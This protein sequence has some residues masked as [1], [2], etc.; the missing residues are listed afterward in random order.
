MLSNYLMLDVAM[1]VCESE[2]AALKLEGKA[3]VID[4]E[5]VQDRG[6]EIMDMYRV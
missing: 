5:Q 1:D 4:A 3:L 2:I 6:I